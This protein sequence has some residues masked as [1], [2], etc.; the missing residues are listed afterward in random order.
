M[1]KRGVDISAHQGNID[2]AAL[3]DQVDFVIIRAG[4]GTKGTLDS[5]FKRNADLCRQLG[6]PVGFYWYSYALDIE[7]VRKEALAFINAIEPYKDILKYGA[8]FDMEDADGYKQKHGMPSDQTLREMCAMF[9]KMVEESGLYA[10]IYASQS[11]FDKQLKGEETARYDKWVAQWPTSGGKQKALDTDSNSRSDLRLWQ[12]TS[13]GRFNGYNGKLDTNYA[14]ADF[15]NPG[16]QPVPVPTPSGTTVELVISVLQ[17][18]YGDG[19]QRKANLGSRYE[20]VQNFINHIASASVDTLVEETK[21][22]TYGNGDQRKL[23][24]GDRYS[25]VQKKINKKST[26]KSEQEITKGSIIRFIGTKSYSGLKL[27]SWTH[28]DR[29]NVIEVSGDRVVIGKGT[30]VTAAVNIKDCKK[31]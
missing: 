2:L 23:L 10:G 12:F 5:K 1:A 22:G 26:S 3:K 9:C 18:E 31:V 24:L 27:A 13:D 25:E 30:A 6:I 8:W 16:S 4:F 21:N 11:W 20:E 17:G 29:F 15:P 14:Y 19:E 28:N 7:G